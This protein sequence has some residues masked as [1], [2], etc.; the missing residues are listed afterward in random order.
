MAKVALDIPTD[1]IK[2][3]LA[4]L[5]PA[6]LQAILASLQGRLETFQMMKL[7]ESAFAEWNDEDDLYPLNAAERAEGHLVAGG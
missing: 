1:A 3:L 2:E 6:E 5:S 7:A 4:Q